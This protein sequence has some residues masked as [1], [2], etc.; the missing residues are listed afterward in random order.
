MNE[1][2]IYGAGGA[3]RELAWNL[4]TSGCK[5][6]CFIEDG[7]TEPRIVHDVEALD[8]EAALRRYKSVP[9]LC[10]VGDCRLRETLVDKAI[11]RGFHCGE[12][13]VHRNVPLSPTTRIG[14]GTIIGSTNAITV[15]NRIGDFVLI[16]SLC[17]V[18]HD[19]EIGDFSTL[20]YGVQISGHVRVGRRVFFGSNSTVVNGDKEH[21][22]VIGDDVVVGAGACVTE[23]IPPGQVVVGVPAKPLVRT[24]Q[25]APDAPLA[26]PAAR[27]R[28]A[29]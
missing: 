1:F 29:R 3:A 17:S 11:K 9:V 4:Q 27:P 6:L 7:C 26:L 15:D 28:T 25:Q 16:H 13:F 12:P 20:C 22:I 24:R 18:C 2:V 21:P 19:V 23:S 5:V 10:A 14:R 8:F